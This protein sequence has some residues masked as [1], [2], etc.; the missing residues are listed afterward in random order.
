MVLFFLQF[1]PNAIEDGNRTVFLFAETCGNAFLASLCLDTP[2]LVF[3]YSKK[4]TQSAK[5]IKLTDWLLKRAPLPNIDTAL[6]LLQS[7]AWD[8]FA[9]KDL[10]FGQ[11]KKMKYSSDSEDK[12]KDK[13]KK[14]ADKDDKKAEEKKAKKRPRSSRSDSSD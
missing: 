10:K 5:L 6:L 14:K 7:I 12:D 9:N 3:D 13:K 11:P 1:S 4:F 8:K 2:I